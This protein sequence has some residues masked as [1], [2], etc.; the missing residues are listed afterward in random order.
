MGC[1]SSFVEAVKELYQLLGFFIPS[2]STT[3]VEE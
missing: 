1:N 3:P 2:L